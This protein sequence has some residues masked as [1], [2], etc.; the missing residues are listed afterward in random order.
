MITLVVP[1]HM[2]VGE[3]VENNLD[4]SC[5]FKTHIGEFLKG[6][7]GSLVFNVVV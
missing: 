4:V 7:D 2:I 5:I 3:S 1:K 6:V